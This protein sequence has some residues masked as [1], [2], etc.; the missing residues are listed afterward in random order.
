VLLLH[1]LVRAFCKRKI[2]A[3]LHCYI[4]FQIREGILV[5]VAWGRRA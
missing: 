4:L 5:F 3:T 2:P 1:S